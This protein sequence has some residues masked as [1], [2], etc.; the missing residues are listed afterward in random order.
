MQKYEK[1]TGAR[2]TIAKILYLC[3]QI[4]V[5]GYEQGRETD[6]TLFGIAE[7]F[8]LFGVGRCVQNMWVC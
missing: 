7:R 6:K 5:A 2:L 3:T 4:S 8:H 1:I